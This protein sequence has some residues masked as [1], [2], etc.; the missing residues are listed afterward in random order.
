MSVKS[1][2][3]KFIPGYQYHV[4]ENIVYLSDGKLIAP[5][6]ID[7][8][9]FESVDDNE[10]VIRFNEFKDF[11]VGVGKQGGLMI[12]SHIIKRRMTLENF[13]KF[14]GNDFLQG[15]SDKYIDSLSTGNF[16]RTDYALTLGLSVSPTADS[17]DD[18]IDKLNEIIQQAKATLSGMNVKTLGLRN[19]ILK[20]D[21]NIRESAADKIPEDH[22]QYISSIASDYLSYLINHDVT[23]IPLSGTT[24]CDSIADGDLG[25]GFDV[26]EIRPAES[27][28]STYCTNYVV[29]DFP[30]TTKN[31]QWDFLL[32]LPFEFILTQSFIAEAVTKSIKKIDSQLNQMES[33]KD[34]GKTQQSE[35]T[36]GQESVQDGTTL[37]GS[38]HAVLSVFGETPE[39]AKDNGIKV[40]SEFITGGKGFRFVKSTQEA[41]ITYFSHLP[42]NKY[43]PLPSKRTL[44]NFACLFSLHNFSY[45]KATGN[46]IGDGTAIMPLKS[47]SDTLYYFNTHYS[48]L[49]KVVTGQKIA[50]HALILGATGAGKTTFEGAATAFLQR[51]DPDLFVI[52]FNRS[53]EL[54]VRAFGGSYF[55]LKEGEQSGLNP[56]QIGDSDDAELM[57]FLKQWVKR[58]AV[59]NTGENCTDKEAEQIDNAVDA[60]MG[61]PVSLRRFSRLLESIPSD[62]DVALR[63]KKWCGTGALAWALDSE[64]NTFNPAD[65]R[66]VGFDTTVILESVG[67]KDH[68]ACEMILSVLFF[69]KNRMQ[70]DG[71]LM[72]TIVEEFWKPANFPMTQEMIKGSLKAGRMKGE[73]IWLTSQSPEDAINC[74]IF[75]AIVQQTST[76]ICL[77]NPDAQENGYRKIGLTRKEFALLKSLGRESRTMLIKQSNSSVFAKMDLYGFD[78][79]LP[80]ISGSQAG[81]RLCEKIRKRLN[82]DDPNVWIPVFLKELPEFEKQF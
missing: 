49:H 30:R 24:I 38:Y 76:K 25:F 23:N 1:R 64:T 28:K 45:G 63:L 12:W 41:P 65:Y 46:P 5:L 54:F 53:T 57:S 11:L 75:P 8:F 10:I 14:K 16:F 31:G 69:Y 72:L 22:N 32:K 21:K 7:G 19:V 39:K 4:D 50:G 6:F 77:P 2:M 80:I 68:P 40:S 79:Y 35:L 51:F 73:M 62:S 70:K 34:A 78:D 3:S 52:D 26:T 66:K 81:V 61:M 59:F 20:E 67:G 58:A 47:V 18:G 36:V 29:K 71:K 33:A 48:D 27:D 42:M 56:F 44:T 74:A 82:T 55:S 37:F 43:R 15:F 9:P 17:I 13:Y 60:V